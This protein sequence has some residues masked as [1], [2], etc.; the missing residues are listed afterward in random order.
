M[1]I[2]LIGDIFSLLCSRERVRLRVRFM[3]Q[4]ARLNDRYMLEPSA[5]RQSRMIRPIFQLEFSVIII[6]IFTSPSVMRK[7][8]A[9]AAL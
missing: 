3:R 2:R 1:H 7:T 4:Y 9:V 5:H 8:V 6:I